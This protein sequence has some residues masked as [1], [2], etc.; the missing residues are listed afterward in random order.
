MVPCKDYAEA[1]RNS[2]RKIASL[3]P[4]PL[5]WPQAAHFLSRLN[6][7]ARA[8]IEPASASRTEKILPDLLLGQ[9]DT[10]LTGQ[11]VCL[12]ELDQF[13]IRDHW[14]DRASVNWSTT[15]CAR[16]CRPKR[17]IAKVTFPPFFRTRSHS[18]H[19]RS[20]HDGSLWLL[21]PAG[22]EIQ[23]RYSRQTP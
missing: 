14:D 4:K 19:C 10:T 17:M 3:P 20:E 23:R 11:N 16:R 9:T 18:R 6:I 13:Q 12:P 8:S 5:L 7:A 2:P 1:K 15:M 21:E 22:L